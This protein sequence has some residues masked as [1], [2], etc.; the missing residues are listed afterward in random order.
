MQDNFGWDKRIPQNI[1]RQWV[2][3]V[4]RLQVLVSI[5]IPRCYKPL[6]LEDIK[7]C[8]IH[9]F[10]DASEKGYGH[11]SYL[12]L[13]DTSGNI[14]CTLLVGKSRVAPIKYLSIPRL[15]LTTATFS[16]KISKM[17]QKELNAELTCNMTEYY[18]IDI[19][20]VLGYIN[21]DA[22]R[23]KVF[24]ANRVQLI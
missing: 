1:E 17:L 10:S 18:W 3:W 15:E 12:R 13:V 24:A 20:V 9:H 4:H 16:G 21:N 8:S 14:H 22:K 2:K 6:K 23:F 19:T 7:D 5:N 11:S